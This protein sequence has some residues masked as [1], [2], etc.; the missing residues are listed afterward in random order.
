MSSVN[1]RQPA[2]LWQ[3][4]N[5]FINEWRISPEHIDHYGHAN[6]VAYVSQLEQTSWAHSNALG[7]TIEQ[8][9]Q[10][11]R[12]MAIS[13]HEINY[14]AA[15][16][17][18]DD[19]ACATWIVECD[20]RLKLTRAFQFIRRADGLCLLTARTEFVCIA[21][22]S[23]RPKRMPPEFTQPYGQAQIVTAGP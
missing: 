15:A 21:L 8:Y 10:L 4:A 17:L 23:G 6:N 13:R 18:H 5:P 12:G 3:Y 19:I 14:L 16:Y 1:H 11:D 22:S 2:L 7:L 9:K 20:N